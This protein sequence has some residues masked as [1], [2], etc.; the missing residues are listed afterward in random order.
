MKF[1]YIKHNY[2]NTASRYKGFNIGDPIQS[3]ALI[4]LYK[5]LGIKDENILPIDMCSLNSYHGE[6]VLLPLCGVAIG[7]QFC[8]LPLPKNIIPIFISAHFAKNNLSKDEVEYIKKYEPI[9][10]R[11]EFSLKLMKRYNIDSYLTGCITITLNKR[12]NT[13]LQKIIYLVD[14]PTELENYIPSEI[15]DNA[16]RLSHLLPLSGNAMSISE[17]NRLIY[18]SKEILDIYRDKAALVISSR[19]HALVP[20]MA[21]GIP[22]VPVFE[23]ISYRFSWF[24]KFVTLYSLDNFAQINWNPKPIDLEETKALFKNIF[25]SYISNN[26]KSSNNIKMLESLNS[27]YNNR[28]RSDYGNRYRKIIKQYKEK[29]GP[30]KTLSQYIIWGC[31]LIGDVVYDIMKEEFP[32]ASMLC[33]CDTFLCKENK[34]FH[35]AKIISPDELIEYPNA[36]IVLSTYSGSKYG[37][38]VMKQLNRVEN[39][40][41]IYVASQNG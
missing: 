16:I 6:K 33:A 14:I 13:N 9:G 8:F 41:F 31:G 24:D 34:L 39:E 20:C 27:F 19:M 17:C 4:D 3:F 22:I 28:N 29:S 11:D 23:N 1:G 35:G 30:L 10:C 5:E 7:I 2:G 12:R 26:I 38:E 36:F 18:T 37:F 25:A 21:M 40:D 15:K 32:N